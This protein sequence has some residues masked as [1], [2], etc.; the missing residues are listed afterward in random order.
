M[1]LTPQELAKIHVQFA[2]FD[3]PEK[4]KKRL[5]FLSAS[6]YSGYNPLAREAKEWYTNEAKL[7]PAATVEM[8]AKDYA[9]RREANAIRDAQADAR[10]FAERDVLAA[11][12]RRKTIV[13]AVAAAL[14]V[15]GIVA[16]IV[17]LATKSKAKSNFLGYVPSRAVSAGVG[18]TSNTGY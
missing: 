6:A 8:L 9:A 5:E 17:Y 15:A 10:Y 7:L 2:P 16:I 13:K 11:E 1:P 14:L 12:K 4:E 18:Y 3:D